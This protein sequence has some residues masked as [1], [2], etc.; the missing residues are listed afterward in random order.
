MSERLEP[1]V[2]LQRRSYRRRRFLDAMKLLPILGIWLFVLPILWPEP[3]DETTSRT[4]S[5]ALIYV[6]GVWLF[7]IL[8]SAIFL[9]AYNAL[10]EDGDDTP[11]EGDA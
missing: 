11:P 9:R 7:L 10:R 6:F 5:G 3:L 1:G 2:F 8:L 4:T